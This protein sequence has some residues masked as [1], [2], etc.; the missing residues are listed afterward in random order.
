MRRRAGRGAGYR[1]TLVLGVLL[2]CL[3][4]VSPS[5]ASVAAAPKTAAQPWKGAARP[6]AAQ[7]VD[8]DGPS[9]T[10]DVKAG[11]TPVDYSFEVSAAG[12][13]EI[14][15]KSWTFP[16][17]GGTSLW[18][19]GAGGSAVSQIF[20]LNGS[21]PEVFGPVT[22]PSS[23]SYTVELDPALPDDTGSVTFEL[24]TVRPIAVGGGV[25]DASVS[26]AGQVTAYQ[27]AGTAG[28][29]LT[30][31]ATDG[32]FPSDDGTQL[33]VTDQAGD[34]ISGV[35]YLNG[36]GPFQSERFT[37]PGTGDY[38][39]VVDPSSS[40]D[41]GGIDLSL[42]RIVDATGTITTDGT[43]VTAT[44]STPGQNDILSF[45]GTA[46]E[47]LALEAT[48][49]TM[50]GFS[51]SVA[52]TDKAGTQIGG[53][54]YLYGG[55]GPQYD[56]LAQ[57]PA[58]GTYHLELTGQPYLGVGQVTL[59][60][61][62]ITDTTGSITVNGSAVTVP[63]TEPEQRAYLDF[64]AKPGEIALT[65]TSSTFGEVDDT[66]SILDSPGT[67]LGSIALNQGSG[68]TDVQIPA[69]GAYRVVIDPTNS[70][71]TGQATIQLRTVVNQTGQ[72][73]L[74]GAPV[75]AS[76]TVPGQQAYFTFTTT[77]ANQ[78][79]SVNVTNS[80]FSTS[81]YDESGLQ[82][83]D[84]SG[85][86]IGPS[87]ELQDGTVGPFTVPTPGTYQLNLD[88]G[89]G[90]ATGQ[91]TLAMVAA[92]TAA[93]PGQAAAGARHHP[94]P[95]HSWT[96]RRP[97]SWTPKS[98]PPAAQDARARRLDLLRAAHARTPARSP[99]PVTARPASSPRDAAQAAAGDATGGSGDSTDSS[100]VW[101]TVN[102]HIVQ[103]SLEG[104]GIDLPINGPPPQGV[105]DTST[106]NL[107]WTESGA[108]PESASGSA[109]DQNHN[110]LTHDFCIVAKYGSASTEASAPASEVQGNVQ[111]TPQPDGSTAYTLTLGGF[112]MSGNQTSQG[113][114]FDT[115]GCGPGD[116]TTTSS[117]TTSAS[118]GAA[119]MTLKGVIPS[120]QDQTT[121]HWDC[122]SGSSVSGSGGLV[123]TASMTQCVASVR[124][125]FNCPT[126]GQGGPFYRV[127][128]NPGYS[129]VKTDVSLSCPAT[130]PPD[131]VRH[132][133]RQ[134]GAVNYDEGYVYAAI[135]APTPPGEKYTQEVE[136][137]L[138]HNSN[139]R[140]S[141]G[142][143]INPEDYKLY[144][145]YETV[146]WQLGGQIP[147]G[148]GQFLL[149][150]EIYGAQPSITVT[151]LK[152]GTSWTSIN[153]DCSPTRTKNCVPQVQGP[154]WGN[155][156]DLCNTAMLTAIGQPI[157]GTGGEIPTP[158]DDGAGYGP[159]KWTNTELISGDAMPLWQ[160]WDSLKPLP[161]PNSSVVKAN[162][163][164]PAY[165][166]TIKMPC[167]PPTGGII[168]SC[169]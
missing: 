161:Y 140:T 115:G 54:Y 37:L 55:N 135:Y 164:E 137:G 21:G 159:V 97:P 4:Q 51:D 132:T 125:G 45:T 126:T 1:L 160:P 16:A 65:Y 156:C 52:L 112:S 33:Y 82:I 57:L 93:G 123:Q 117:S 15:T 5:L 11:G 127:C 108:Q 133:S 155:G 28:E 36:S 25:V 129:G 75:T 39:V 59:R 114:E 110:Y 12:T 63:V 149:Q 8:V 74:D 146:F 31:N 128:S 86:T 152:T 18:V 68:A 168:W 38:D 121:A 50:P 48:N 101:F 10:A 77:K 130:N 119:G 141:S 80:T 56:R 138:E 102:Q 83:L 79:F 144:V 26:T 43:P 106:T 99:R 22:L 35:T 163:R 169:S 104:S 142:V 150:A 17:D 162:G 89:N 124:L 2:G 85:G 72:I 81:P 131:F 23:G 49:A 41:T 96:P 71:G 58:T 113:Y 122:G 32:T 30:V 157:P 105:V 120:G 34:V 67:S 100:N 66:A 78:Q 166:V 147:C 62:P 158:Y 60:L 92:G 44:L 107:Q 90:T 95:A 148:N 76:L 42:A 153:A 40:G 46:G 69:A 91:A 143:P 167:D 64:S 70:G 103:T 111:L 165:N 88:P 20:L 29:A 98:R 73:S 94:V 84:S 27:F 87:Y 19:L 13:I 145:R 109:Q 151:S 3:C 24:T 14:N 6:Q 53:S 139:P 136:M 61:T 154:E 9:V 7:V 118:V 116:V 134:S 47:V